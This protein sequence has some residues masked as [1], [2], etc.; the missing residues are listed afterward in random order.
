MH[1]EKKIIMNP[2]PSCFC[3]KVALDISRHSP[4]KDVIYFD[5][6]FYHKDCFV[7]MQ[8]KQVKQKCYFCKKDIDCY[9]DSNELLFYD[10]HFYHSNCFDNWCHNTKKPSTKRMTALEN[11]STYINIAN[12]MIREIR[13]EKHSKLR[14]MHILHE[15]TIEHINQWFDESD[16]CSF[17]RE[18]YKI[19]VVPWKRIEPVLRGTDSR[20]PVAIPADILLD[21]WMRKFN[22]L[23]K[24]NQKLISKSSTPI[25]SENLIAYDLTILIN[26]YDS[27]MKWREEQRILAAENSKRENN[28]VQEIINMSSFCSKTESNKKGDD[29]ISDLVNDIFG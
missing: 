2:K 26:K 9:S 4:N 13:E 10:K 21:M 6:R 18:A 25:S 19:T 23:Q 14:N 5:K 1:F 17:L 15:A 7:K 22:Y 12:Q 24:Q 11:K 8:N 16:L 20:I 29:D 28:M 27:Y 3:C